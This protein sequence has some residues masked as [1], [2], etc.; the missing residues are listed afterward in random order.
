MKSK[1]TKE[2]LLHHLL[3]EE[4]KSRRLA[5]LLHEIGLNDS[6]YTVTLNEPIAQLLQLKTDKEFFEYDRLM[7]RHAKRL[8]GDEY[9]LIQEILTISSTYQDR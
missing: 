1:M 4:L 6:R 2:N 8:K 7:D 5:C 3:R 9:S